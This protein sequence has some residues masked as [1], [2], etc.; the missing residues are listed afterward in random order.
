[1]AEQD[2]YQSHLGVNTDKAPN[3]PSTSG[4]EQDRYGG[5][6]GRNRVDQAEDKVRQNWPRGS[7]AEQDR[8]D[9]WFGGDKADKAGEAIKRHL[10]KV[11]GAEQDRY[12]GWFG[13]DKLPTRADIERM[14]PKTSGAEQ[15][16]YEGWFGGHKLPSRDDFNK[17]LPTGSGAE[18]D[19]Y[20]GWFGGDKAPSA[21]RLNASLTTGSAAE[22][23]RYGSH[24][25]SDG[26]HSIR[27]GATTSTL[28]LI[29]HAVL[30]SFGFHTGLGVIAYGVGRYTNN[31][32]AKDWL[33]PSGQVANAWW[34]AIGSRVLYDGLSASAAWSS[35]SYQQKLLLTG[36]SAWGIRL[37]Y[38]TASRRLRRGKDDPRY[39]VA[40]KEPGF[41][42]KALF[43]MYLPEAALQTLI[44][45]PFTLPFRA[46]VASAHASPFPDSS[47]ISHSL[48]IFLFTAGYALE[49]IA[50]YQLEA[51]SQKDS[52]NLNRD[53]VWSIVRH[54]NYLGD[55]LLHISLPLLLYSAGQLHPLV[56]LG[57]VANY[58][59]LRFISGDKE[60]EANQESRYSKENPVK[61]Q[62]LQ[63][64]KQTKN[65]F[66]PTLHEVNNKWLWIVTAAGAGG[67][68]LERS[69][70]SY[71]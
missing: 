7:G 12:D 50:D 35:L 32:E 63:E 30:P 67:A 65:S 24:F 15:D 60:N 57:P 47:G 8:Y 38:R 52:T 4:A 28:G 51:H 27:L 11:S 1:M 55:A 17:R 14:L 6:F 9:G 69:L 46:P 10:P 25:K 22:Q 2:R 61:Y 44:T 5:W 70:R 21:D 39:D 3:L 26:P 29:Q 18:Q 54:P 64:Y 58:L 13:G 23:D 43:S 19:R 62:Q 16:R 42:N 68:I 20:G 66:W 40:K 48:A 56:L 37:F 31:A 49:S 45:L 33:W 36:I 71:L 34:S 53:G 41:W 59:F